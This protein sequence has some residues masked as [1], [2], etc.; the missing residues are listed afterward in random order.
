MLRLAALTGPDSGR[1]QPRDSQHGERLG[2]NLQ[3]ALAALLDEHRLPVLEAEGDQVAVIVRR[4]LARRFP[5]L[6][7]EER[8]IRRVDLEGLVAGLMSLE[9]LVRDPG[10]A[11][12]GAERRPIG[13]DSPRHRWRRRS[14]DSAMLAR[15]PIRR[16]PAWTSQLS[17]GTESSAATIPA[18]DH[19]VEHTIAQPC[20]HRDHWLRVFPRGVTE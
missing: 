19:A 17:R 15:V 20:S 8:L 14:R 12:D 7:R 16:T 6:G 18:H 1:I 9:Q 13:S 5:A 11:R 3:R 10:V 2:P 4:G